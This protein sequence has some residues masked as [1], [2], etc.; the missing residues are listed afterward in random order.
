MLRSIGARLCATIAMIAAANAASAQEPRPYRP[1]F[2]VV[3]YALTIDLPDTGA[4][5]RANAV[6]SVARTGQRDT[7]LLDLLDLKVDR[8]TVDGRV[9]PVARQPGTIAISVPR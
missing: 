7:L 3:D 8:V 4:T 1:A 9:V 5:I 2:D 6:L